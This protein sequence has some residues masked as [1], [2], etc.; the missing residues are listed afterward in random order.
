MWARRDARRRIDDPGRLAQL[1]RALPLQGRGRRF[2]SVNAHRKEMAAVRRLSLFGP[3]TVLRGIRPAR[4]RRLSE[5]EA[6]RRVSVARSGLWRSGGRWRSLLR[7]LPSLTP[8]ESSSPTHACRDK[9]LQTMRFSRSMAATSRIAY[10]RCA[11]DHSN[12]AMIRHRPAGS[13]TA[14]TTSQWTSVQ[15]ANLWWPEDRAWCV[16]TEMDF[17]WTYVGGDIAPVEEL[18]GDSTFE[19]LPARIDDAITWD[20]D[21]INPPPRDQ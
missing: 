10:R 14:F 9:R 7:P 12:T 20:A 8:R 4:R 1:A 13:R 21:R 17:S 15:S 16:A 5:L 11:S 6:L 19:A 3:R 18:M 2:E